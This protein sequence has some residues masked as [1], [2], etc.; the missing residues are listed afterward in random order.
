[1]IKQLI[2]RIDRALLFGS[3]RRAYVLVSH[4][5]RLRKISELSLA[6]FQFVVFEDELSAQF[7]K[8]GSDK[9]LFPSASG[10]P[11]HR[12]SSVYQSLF[13]T[14]RD[15]QFAMLEIG[16][17]TNK[18]DQVSNM[19]VD[20][21][22]GASLQVW[23]K[24]FRQSDI[25]A[26]DIDD[27]SFVGNARVKTGVADQTDKNQVETCMK[28]FENPSFSIVIDD[29][30]HTPQGNQRAFEN[31]RPWLAS[32]ALYVIE[33]IHSSN[34]QEMAHWARQLRLNYSFYISEK[35][36]EENSNLMVIHCGGF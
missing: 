34:L 9:G 31:L 33:D 4:L 10:L 16:I 15:K 12:Y 25:Y 26:F 27:L 23:E 32:G 36:E 14:Y 21:C 19:G 5:I 28:Q 20:G 24:F 11:G 30:L 1:M 18:T 35:W 29:G 22:V 7:A 13:W 17:G 8:A 3:I 6:R 2:N